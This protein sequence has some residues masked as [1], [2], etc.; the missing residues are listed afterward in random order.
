MWL[1]SLLTEL[2]IPYS[3]PHIYCDN[4]STVLLCH[5][6]VL[7]ARTK[8]IELDMFFVR[9]RVIAGQLQVTHVPSDAQLAD[10]L[11]KPLSHNR[12]HQLK[13][14]LNLLDFASLPS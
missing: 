13:S 4:Q 9:E 12:F 6:P 11:T 5:N 14:N 7:H 1:E 3:V 10:I 8:H 2:Q